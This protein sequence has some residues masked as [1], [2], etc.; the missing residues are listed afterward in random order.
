MNTKLLCCIAVSILFATSSVRAGVDLV[1]SGVP[2]DAP[3]AI[4]AIA[5]ATDLIVDIVL[6]PEWHVYSVTWAAANPFRLLSTQ[7]A[8]S[9]LRARCTCRNQILGS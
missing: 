6:E 1:V 7:A 3:I 5:T 9:L 8:R 4:K 2:N